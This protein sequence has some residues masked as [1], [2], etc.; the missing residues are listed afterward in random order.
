MSL[1]ARYNPNKPVA[2]FDPFVD[3]EDVFRS[4]GTRP[5]LRDYEVM[6][7]FRMDVDEF[8]KFYQVKAEIPGVKKDDIVISIDQ[9]LVSI[10][11][12][13]KKEMTSKASEKTIHSERY[14]GKWF[15]SFSL[16]QEVD[17]AKAEAHFED[18]ILTLKLPKKPN[19]LSRRIAVN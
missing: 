7:E 16:P 11:A 10:S 4:L 6:P 3:F 14:F 18:G 12:E 13:V 15:R 5:M 17:D 8:D 1:L 19:G 9:K 2:R